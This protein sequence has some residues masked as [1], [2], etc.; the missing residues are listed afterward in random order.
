M[1]EL[2]ENIRSQ[3]ANIPAEEHQRINGNTFANARNVH[4]QR[5]SIFNTS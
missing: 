2:K 5:D 4:V 1:E 3:V